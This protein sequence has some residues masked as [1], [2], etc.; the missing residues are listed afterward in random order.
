MT[1]GLGWEWEPLDVEEFGNTGYFSHGYLVE[2]N[3]TEGWRVWHLDRQV[4]RLADSRSE[5]SSIA[6]ADWVAELIQAR[7]ELT[8]MGLIVDSGERKLSTDGELQIVWRL[9]T[10]EERLAEKGIEQT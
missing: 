7:E 9:K 4:F 6:E 1:E 2:R 5:A 8:A 3:G 10:E